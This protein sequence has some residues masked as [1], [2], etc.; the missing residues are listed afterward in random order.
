MGKQKPQ[1][2]ERNI[3]KAAVPSHPRDCLLT[4][5]VLSVHSGPQCLAVLF[6]HLCPTSGHD[7]PL[8]SASF[9]CSALVCA[10]LPRANERTNAGHAPRDQGRAGKGMFLRSSAASWPGA[11]DVSTCGVVEKS[12]VYH[13]GRAKCDCV[14]RRSPE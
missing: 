12:C 10:R 9:I 8:F 6:A 7:A 1:Q 2:P 4:A 3:A 13:R 5:S 14:S 11:P